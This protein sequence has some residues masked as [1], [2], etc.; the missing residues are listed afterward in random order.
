MSEN[1][2]CF[3]KVDKNRNGT[4]GTDSGKSPEPDTRTVSEKGWDGGREKWTC[5]E[6]SPLRAGESR[7]VFWNIVCSREE[8][9][10]QK[11]FSG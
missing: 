7:G 5:K 9:H 1:D 10:C 3:R 6:L 8:Q 11:E 4:A 2:C